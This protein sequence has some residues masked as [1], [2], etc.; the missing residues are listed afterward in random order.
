L[1]AEIKNLCF[2]ICYALQLNETR[3]RKILDFCVELRLFDDNVL[4]N[5][6]ALSSTGIQ[7]RYLEVAKRLKKKYNPEILDFKITSKTLNII[8]EETPVN[9][10]KT[11]PIRKEIPVNSGLIP[12][13]E[14]EKEKKGK[15]K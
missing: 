2:D 13:K 14:R 3:V 5:H 8:P 12:Q 9:S 10:D 11:P 1:Q 7:L 4:E 15:E 6:Q